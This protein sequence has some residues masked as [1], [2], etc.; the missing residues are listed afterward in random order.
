MQG[1]VP[2]RFA[3]VRAWNVRPWGLKFNETEIEAVKRE[4]GD[5]IVAYAGG[6][7]RLVVTNAN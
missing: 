7:M 4:F 2:A 3:I 6:T 1:Q 5:P